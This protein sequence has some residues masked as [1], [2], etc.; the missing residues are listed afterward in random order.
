MK[1]KSAPPN[2]RAIKSVK[3]ESWKCTNSSR[4][5]GRYSSCVNCNVTKTT[6]M[7][8]MEAAA[9]CNLNILSGMRDD[10][11]LLFSFRGGDSF[12]GW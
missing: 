9:F 12:G 11:L 7:E 5:L 10:C 4:L 6:A 2:A 8:L 1:N 3:L